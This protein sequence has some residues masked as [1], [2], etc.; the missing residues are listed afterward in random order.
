MVFLL[1]FVCMLNIAQLNSEKCKVYREHITSLQ[2]TVFKAQLRFKSVKYFSD[3]CCLLIPARQNLV[4]ARATEKQE[5][6]DI[7]IWTY[8][9]KKNISS[10]FSFF[11]LCTCKNGRFFFWLQK[12]M[13]Y[14][15]HFLWDFFFLSKKHFYISLRVLKRCKIWGREKQKNHWGYYKT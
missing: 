13:N 9:P 8:N 5:E 7:P 11:L 15:I 1:L 14:G 3:F 4:A 2:F 10:I 6:G 12:K